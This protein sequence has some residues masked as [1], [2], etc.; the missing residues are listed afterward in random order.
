MEIAKQN[1][2]RTEK[3]ETE[4][5]KALGDLASKM[6]NKESSREKVGRKEEHNKR[7]L[8]KLAMILK[9]SEH[10]AELKEDEQH[11]MELVIGERKFQLNI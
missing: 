1:A 2:E 10:R 7:E 8:K 11:K 3:R 6:A 4:L 9:E 5:E